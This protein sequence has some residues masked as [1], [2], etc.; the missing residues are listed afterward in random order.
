MFHE[1]VQRCRRLRRQTEVAQRLMA[2]FAGRGMRV[3]TI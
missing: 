1:N 3:S 2:E